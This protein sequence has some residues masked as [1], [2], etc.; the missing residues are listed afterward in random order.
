M[1]TTTAM[2]PAFACPVP[3]F[4]FCGTKWVHRDNRLSG[5][6]ALR[7]LPSLACWESGPMLPHTCPRPGAGGDPS[8]LP[9]HHNAQEKRPFLFFDLHTSHLQGQP[10]NMHHLLHPQGCRT[11]HPGPFPSLPLALAKWAGLAG[12]AM[13]AGRLSFCRVLCLLWMHTGPEHT[14]LGPE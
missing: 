13:G 1:T 2:A 11:P 12:D 6:S 8:Q 7:Q 14:T 9:C 4:P 10:F 3:S 5:L